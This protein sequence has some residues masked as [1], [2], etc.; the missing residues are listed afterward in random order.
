MADNILP[1][2]TVPENPTSYADLKSALPV[3]SLGIRGGVGD[4]KPLGY[5]KSIT[6]THSRKVDPILQLEPYLN[7]TFDDSQ[8]NTLPTGSD[9][10]FVDGANFQGNLTHMPGERVEVVPGPITDEKV[11][12]SRTILYTSTLFEAL[13][14]LHGGA[15]TPDVNNTKARYINLLQQTRPFQIYEIYVDPLTG[16]IFW[17]IHYRDCF[18][19]NLPRTVSTEDTNMTEDIDFTVTK[20]RFYTSK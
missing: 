5:A 1:I 15:K 13:M 16:D 14:H 11:K 7:G 9:P 4:I 17:G 2:G 8:G 6:R 20:T 12:L 19:E 10:N 18:A 3:L